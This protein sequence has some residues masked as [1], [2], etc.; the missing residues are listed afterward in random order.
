MSQFEAPPEPGSGLVELVRG[1]LY[2]LSEVRR[3]LT[4]R[5]PYVNA[6]VEGTEVYLRVADAR[7][8]M[9]VLEG[10][11]AATPGAK[12]AVPFAPAQVT[13]GQQLA[14]AAGALPSVSTLPD[15]GVSFGALRRVT[16]GALSWTLFYPEV[17]VGDEAAASTDRRLRRGCWRRASVARPRPSWPTCP[18]LASA[19]G[20][21]AALRTSI[22]VARRDPA[23][24]D[25]QAAR[26][27]ALAPDAAAPR[28]AL[29]YARQLALDLDGAVAAA[30]GAAARASQAP[31]P[32]ARLAELYLMQGDTAR[33]RRAADAAAALGAGPLT[34]IAQGF[35]DLA[36]V[37]RCGGG[38]RVSP[39]PAAR[40][41]ESPRHC[42]GS[43]SRRSAVAISPRARCSYRT[44]PWRIPPARSCAPTW[45]R[46]SSPARR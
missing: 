14:A 8:D 19:G 33:S 15:D 23:A 2:F 40:E 35:A 25:A 30:D 13:T 1:G 39:C 29:S 12:S 26:A 31:L 20:L 5:T 16:V 9:I 27:V 44:R 22:A 3:T 46:P 42:S 45:A 41:P 34:D 37:P 11:V 28:L 10:K 6:G 38:G 36:H 43:G 24:A 17:L 4:V 32:Q 21:A 18:M 7:T